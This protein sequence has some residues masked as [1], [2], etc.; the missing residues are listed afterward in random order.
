[1]AV[2]VGGSD[3]KPAPGCIGSVG[4]QGPA[5][6]LTCGYGETCKVGAIHLFFGRGTKITSDIIPDLGKQ[7]SDRLG[8]LAVGS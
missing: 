7:L 1:M 2:G 5:S 3:P 4:A 8:E 6:C